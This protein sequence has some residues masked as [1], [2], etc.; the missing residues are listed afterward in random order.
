MTRP[1]LP[2]RPLGAS[3][4][5]AVL[6]LA[7]TSKRTQLV[8]VVDTDT[9][10]A[11][12]RSLRMRCAYEWDGIREDIDPGNCE[13]RWSRGCSQAQLAVP[14]SLGVLPDPTRQG[15]TPSQ[16]RITFV[17]EDEMNPDH[18]RIA[19]VAPVTEDTS[20]V[21]LNLP[22]LCASVSVASATHPCPATQSS[23]TNSRSCETL[24]QLMGQPLTCGDNGMCRSIDLAPPEIVSGAVNP[25]TNSCDA[26]LGDGSVRDAA[27]DTGP[28]G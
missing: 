4:V 11:T 24:G 1:P 14:A 9:T 2:P 28:R 10:A 15:G 3:A 8:V 19:R 20:T 27:A 5:V 13:Q 7:C 21:R 25:T 18:R 16:R 17:L 22:A 23:C 12:V 6:M 26:S